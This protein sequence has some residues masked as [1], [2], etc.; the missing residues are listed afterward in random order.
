MSNPHQKYHSIEVTR[1]DKL[2]ILSEAE[3]AEEAAMRDAPAS[4][5][6]VPRLRGYNI[7]NVLP[8]MAGFKKKEIILSTPLTRLPLKMERWNMWKKR[9]KRKRK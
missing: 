3:N 5:Q 6:Y 7:E 8:M 9:L 4:N 2:K 1:E